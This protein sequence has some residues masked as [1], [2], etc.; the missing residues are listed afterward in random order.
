MDLV[1]N[2]LKHG[3]FDKDHVQKR[4]GETFNNVVVNLEENK[5]QDLRNINSFD[6]KTYIQ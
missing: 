5:V 6:E 2:E 1:K 4:W 3:Q